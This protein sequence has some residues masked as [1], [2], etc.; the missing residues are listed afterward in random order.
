MDTSQYDI[1][2]SILPYYG[3]TLQLLRL[4]L[5]DSFKKADI[6]LSREQLIILIALHHHNGIAQNELA[7]ETGRNK[8]TITRLLSKL[9][10]KKLISRIQN[11]NDKR[12]NQV[13]ITNE[14]L[15]IMNT[16]LPIMLKT[17]KLLEE[18]ISEEE[19]E[20]LKSASLKIQ[21][22]LIELLKST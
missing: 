15:A 2:N 5:K 14:G 10:N 9:E 11:K 7:I 8:T 1:K 12:I 3:K 19:L 17:A 18:Q 21:S 13:Y 6:S 22:T 4:Y 16:T 20:N